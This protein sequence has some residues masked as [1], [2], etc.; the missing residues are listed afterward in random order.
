MEALENKRIKPVIMPKLNFQIRLVVCSFL[1]AESLVKVFQF[2]SKQDKKLVHS[3]YDLLEESRVFKIDFKDFEDY[4]DLPSKRRYYLR[5]YYM[6]MIKFCSSVELLFFSNK[7]F[8]QREP[9]IM[10]ADFLQKFNKKCTVNNQYL[11]D[12][13]LGDMPFDYDG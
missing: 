6:N 12:S 1:D 9:F 3:N 7:I 13:V 10:I 2:I 5:R 4:K 11:D 8:G